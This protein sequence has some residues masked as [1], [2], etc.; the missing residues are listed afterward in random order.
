LWVLLPRLKELELTGDILIKGKWAYLLIALTGSFLTF[1]AEVWMIRLS[2]KKVPPWI[3]T[4]IIEIGAFTAAT[5]TPGGLGWMVIN[6]KYLEKSGNDSDATRMALTL[7]I[8]LTLIAGLFLTVLSL[9]FHSIP[10]IKTPHVSNIF[11]IVAI[12]AVVL[13]TA[14]IVFLIPGY[15]KWVIMEIRTIMNLLPDIIKNPSRTIL[16]IIAAVLSQFAYAITLVTSIAAYGPTPP[17]ASIFIAYIIATIVSKVSPTPGGLG[18]METALIALLS[19]NGVIPGVAV[20]AVLSFR[21]FTFWIPLLFGFWA[22]RYAR[23]QKWI[24]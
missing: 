1:I 21:F 3:R 5:I 22:L 20:A 23:V 15:R 8:F 12:A 7:L 4:T 11:T 9:P 16:M 10:W 18:P 17:V 6:Q 2:V 19:Q 24:S 13:V 14:G